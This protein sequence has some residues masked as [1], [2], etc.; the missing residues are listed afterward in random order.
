MSDGTYFQFNFT[1]TTT[2]CIRTRLYLRALVNSVSPVFQNDF[3]SAFF[4]I[5]VTAA[6]PEKN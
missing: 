1:N 6:F 2:G 3:I 4:H 5:D